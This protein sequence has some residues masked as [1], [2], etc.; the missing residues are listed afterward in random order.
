M[1]EHSRNYVYREVMEQKDEMIVNSSVESIIQTDSQNRSILFFTCK[2][3]V[4]AQMRTKNQLAAKRC[5]FL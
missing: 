5:I 4:L 2:A 1:P 3:F